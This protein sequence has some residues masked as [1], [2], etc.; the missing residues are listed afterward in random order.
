MKKFDFEICPVCESELHIN[1]L[2]CI[3]C[4][5]EFPVDKPISKYDL[6]PGEQKEFLETFLRNR[7]NIKTVGEDLHISY[8]TV[9]RRLEELLINLG[10]EEPSENDCEVMLD[11]KTF[12]ALDLDSTV[13][14]EIIRRKMYENGGSVVIPLLDGKLCRIVSSSDGKSFTSDKL[15]KYQIHYEYSVFNYIVDLLKQSKNY[16]APKGNGH[17]K[18]DKVG[19]GKCTEDTIVGTIAIKYLKKQ[20]GTSTYD[21]VFVL[22]A[23]LDWAGIGMN[24]RGFV[25]LHPNYIDKL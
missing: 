23:I 9:K 25:S 21:P 22:A 24:Q 11:M 13:P 5:S 4:K 2:S 8:P 17:G 15:N 19:Y 12:G 7:G 1:R 20:Y 14:S 6:L 16:R 10:L 18:E 3:N